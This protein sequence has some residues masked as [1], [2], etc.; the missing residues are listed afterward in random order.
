MARLDHIGHLG[1]PQR[2]PPHQLNSYGHQFRAQCAVSSELS[3]VVAGMALAH[4][5]WT[6][7]DVLIHGHRRPLHRRLSAMLLLLGCYSV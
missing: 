2:H 3:T 7:T 5:G 1:R 6:A 4:L